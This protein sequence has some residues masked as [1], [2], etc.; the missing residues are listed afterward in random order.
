M[1]ILASLSGAG[2]GALGMLKKLAVALGNP[3]HLGKAFAYSVYGGT[4]T[5][6]G[7]SSANLKVGSA[8]TSISGVVIGSSQV[9]SPNPET[10]LVAADIA[11]ATA[12]YNGLTPSGS[13]WLGAAPVVTSPYFAADMA[14]IRFTPGVYFAGAAITNS[15]AVTC[16]AQGDPNA[17]F[18]FQ[19]G[20]A[21]A[22]AASSQVVLI[23]GAKEENVFWSVTG[24]TDLGAGATF[25]G[26]IISP[27]AIALGAGAKMYGRILTNAGAVTMSANDVVTV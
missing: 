9:F 2:A 23:N 25:R 7:A 13:M 3:T 15:I 8:G 6:A 24:A 21:F 19:I 20:A 12:Y 18:V 5:V 10:L 16:D 11:A 1:P 22:P 27:A 14:G 26:T 4:V 17:T